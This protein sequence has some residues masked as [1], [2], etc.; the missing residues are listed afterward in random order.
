MESLTRPEEGDH[1]R[2]ALTAIAAGLLRATGP[3]EP[4]SEAS[5]VAA[6]AA[7]AQLATRLVVSL[8]SLGFDA[9]WTR[10]LVLV[11][12]TAPMGDRTHTTAALGTGPPGLR[13]LVRGCDPTATHDLLLAVLASFLG[14]LV[15]FI[16]EP[17]TFRIIHQ[18]WPALPTD[19]ADAA[20][21]QKGDN[22]D[23]V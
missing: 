1:A 7:Y 15:T 23:H 17:L 20:P 13:E 2:P 11:A 3:G 14:L 21:D 6:E 8:G 5:I 10:A 9:L 4:S 18:L 19:A 12:R 22:H 16:G